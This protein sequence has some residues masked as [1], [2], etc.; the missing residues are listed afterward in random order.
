[1][2]NLKKTI[3]AAAILIFQI[4][5][6]SCATKAHDAEPSEPRE[7]EILAL[8][9][10]AL[11]GTNWLKT[12][13]IDDATKKP[14][15][16]RNFIIYVVFGGDREC[17]EITARSDENGWLYVKNIPDGRCFADILPDESEQTEDA[18]VLSEKYLIMRNGNAV[19]AR[20]GE[21]AVEDF[22]T[23]NRKDP[24]QVLA[25]FFNRYLKQSEDWKDFVAD[26]PTLD[27][28]KEDLVR[29]MSE[30]HKAFYGAADSISIEI[31]PE[32]TAR[33]GG[34]LLFTIRIACSHNGEEDEGEDDVSMIRDESGNW[35]VLE[36]PR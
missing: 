28:A 12:Q 31:N 16:N 18:G 21:K 26:F 3:F 35:F 9:N 36:L 29:N 7:S 27:L 22:P 1:M 30:A 24:A 5:L 11:D 2:K 4:A 15:A 14:M 10:I 8:K 20:R 23:P 6:F 25:A 33:N 32:K 17:G 13:F 34:I 19:S